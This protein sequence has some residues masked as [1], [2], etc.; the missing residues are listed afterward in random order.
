M[1]KDELDRLPQNLRQFAEAFERRKETKLKCEKDPKMFVDSDGN[2]IKLS[3]KTRPVN[4]SLFIIQMCGGKYDG[5]YGG[6]DTKE[7][8]WNDKKALAEDYT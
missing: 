1:T 3:K 7:E 5:K 2:V 6:F 4:E 8:F